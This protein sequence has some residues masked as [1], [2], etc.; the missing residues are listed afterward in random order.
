MTGRVLYD[1]PNAVRSGLADCNGVRA[2]WDEVNGEVQRACWDAIEWGDAVTSYKYTTDDDGRLTVAAVFGD[3]SRDAFQ[4][5]LLVGT[6]GRYSAVRKFMEGDELPPA[7]FGPPA[8]ADFR[9][10]ARESDE[11]APILRGIV[12]DMLRVYNVPD[13][14]LVAPGGK[15]AHLA[16]DEPFVAECMRGVARGGIM[17]IRPPPETGPLRTSGTYQG[18][19]LGHIGIW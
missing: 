10:V 5:D 18:G 4:A 7:R 16:E 2:R 13:L 9:V 17:K 1:I 11:I 8:I 12:D 19:E 3:G 14:S 15:Y 6:D